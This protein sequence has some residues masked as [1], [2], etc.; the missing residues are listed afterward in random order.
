MTKSHKLPR[1]SPIK[2]SESKSSKSK[3]SKLQ[4]FS[5][6]INKNIFTSPPKTR[7]KSVDN[8]KYIKDGNKR[9]KRKS[10]SSRRKSKKKTIKK[11]KE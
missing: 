1:F 8:L 6:I 2:L 10:K 5:P 3:S 9:T 7:R 4:R 11:E